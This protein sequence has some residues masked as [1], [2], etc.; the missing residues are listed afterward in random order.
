MALNIKAETIALL[1]V[2]R[3]MIFKTFISGITIINMAGMIAKYLAISLAILKVVNAPLVIKSCFP[4]STTS[5]I[6]VGSESKST[7]LA[8]SLAAVVP[9]FIASPT[10]A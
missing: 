10:S 6:L 5:R 9:L 1:V 4:I 8:A 2:A 7:I 3:F